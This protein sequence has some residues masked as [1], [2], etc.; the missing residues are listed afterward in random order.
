[1]FL[2]RLRVVDEGEG[3]L[4]ER[5][6]RQTWSALREAGHRLA[7]ERG[8]ENVS[9]EEIAAAANVSKRTLFNYFDSKEELLFGPDPE[10]PERLAALVRERPA[11]EPL[12]SSLREVVAGYVAVHETRFRLHKQFRYASGGV[13]EPALAACV[14]GRGTGDPLHDELL[15]RTAMTVLRTAFAMWQPTQDYAELSRLVRHGFDLVAAGLGT[16][17]AP[18]R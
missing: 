17:R 16:D 14:A 5:K 12:W 4:R 11:G 3:G 1:M 18:V 2:P 7:A 10:D 6:K 9:V 15:T 13:L 8:V